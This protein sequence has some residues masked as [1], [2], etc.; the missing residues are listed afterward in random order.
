MSLLRGAPDFG[1]II[2]SSGHKL[3][4]AWEEDRRFVY[5]PAGLELSRRGD[6]AGEPDFSL[7]LVRG[8][9]PFL[10]PQPYG[11]LDFRLR[12]HPVP[13]ELLDDLR[14]SNPGAVVSPAVFSRGY[15]RLVLQAGSDLHA[16]EFE[17]PVTLASNGLDSTRY[18]RRLTPEAVALLKRV[19]Q[20]GT[21]TFIAI[22]EMEVIGL[23][24]R[25]PVR[26]EFQPGELHHALSAAA[27]KDSLITSG[28]LISFWMRSLSSLPVRFLT[29]IESFDR[30]SL[31]E[32]L[33]DWTADELSEFVP[34][35]PGDP[36]PTFRLRSP[37]QPDQLQRWDLSEG[38]SVPRIVIL[39]LNPFD[40]VR[41]IVV[42]QGLQAVFKE[43]QVP[44]LET[45]F[46]TM[47]VSANLPDRLHG[48][49]RLGV[50]LLAPPNPPDRVSPL[51]RS[52][53]LDDPDL[54]Q[55]FEWRFAPHEPVAF[56]FN[57]FAI[58]R[59]PAGISRFEAQSGFHD[60][61]YLLLKPSDFPLAFVPL[62]ASAGLLGEATIQGVCRYPN[63][64]GD[65]GLEIPFELT[66]ALPSIT[67]LLPPAAA[68][69]AEISLS[70]RAVDGSA[71]IDLGSFPAR[72]INLDLSSLPEYGPHRIQIEAQFDEPLSLLAIDFLPQG[73]MENPESADT[74]AFTPEKST[75][76]WSYF[77]TSPFRP[78]FAYRLNTVAG[79][80]GMS[81]AISGMSTPPAGWSAQ[82]S[83]FAPLRLRASQFIESQGV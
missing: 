62:Q 22:A 44:P 67:L 33:A 4:S 39:T 12:S 3:F 59:Q 37:S 81:G 53:L 82:Q 70:A 71:E 21:L 64:D 13:T 46:T 49:V 55:T 16:P 23:A 10:P 11:V 20:E 51:T 18:I 6:P 74:I 69:L 76:A 27:N 78:G 36:Q 7:E 28:S 25:L 5:L 24:P 15:L 77:A 26:L 80:P 17:T 83:P 42:D 34:F 29:D 19:L 61:A 2:N 30:L 58:L 31:A 43:T 1:R 50:N 41:Q 75:A 32:I 54:V 66:A 65:Q 73:R 38:R 14:Q 56:Q 79:A 72:A 8:E 63:P 60:D 40:A 35:V 47:S 9:N 68:E 45:G 52:L 48:V 57:T